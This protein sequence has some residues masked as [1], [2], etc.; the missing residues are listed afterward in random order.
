MMRLFNFSIFGTFNLND[1]MIELGRVISEDGSRVCHSPTRTAR[2]Y[3]FRQWLAA[4][5]RGLCSASPLYALGGNPGRI[6]LFLHRRR[7]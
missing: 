1:W 4:D 7:W 5:G 6:D 3:G 2:T